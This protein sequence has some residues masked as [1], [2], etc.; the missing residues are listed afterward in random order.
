MPSSSQKSK[1]QA[2]PEY[3]YT[4]S[5]LPGGF[6]LSVRK[7]ANAWWLDREK[8]LMLFTAF[9]YRGGTKVA[10]SFAGITLRQY[11]YFVHL[12]PIV[13]DIKEAYWA[14]LAIKALENVSKAIKENKNTKDSW[15][16]LSLVN[17]EEWGKY[18]KTRTITKKN[19]QEDKI[20]TIAE[21]EAES[22]RSHEEYKKWLE[23]EKKKNK[24]QPDI[25]I[26]PI[27]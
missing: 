16:W 18:R 5:D 11:K 3:A 8:V 19:F 20:W 23:E 21:I 12:H 22:N 17:P 9:K 10:C 26:E 6:I 25:D 27:A 24:K 14:T 1:K 15:R 4:I 13:P 7:T 2:E